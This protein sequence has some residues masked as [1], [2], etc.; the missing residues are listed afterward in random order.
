MKR[1]E[2]IRDIATLIHESRDIPGEFDIG[3]VLE[4]AKDILDY[5]EEVGM[6]PPTCTV[7][8]IPD[9]QRG[10]FKHSTALPQWDEE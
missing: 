10:G 9:D 8:L 5:I 3:D 4:T 6:L 7:K 1:S 2:M